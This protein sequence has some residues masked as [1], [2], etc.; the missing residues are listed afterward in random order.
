MIPL[1][2][3]TQPLELMQGRETKARTWL[4]ERCARLELGK[5]TIFEER[6]IYRE[7]NVLPL[8]GA[9]NPSGSTARG[10]RRALSGAACTGDH[11]DYYHP[12][13]PKHCSICITLV[14]TIMFWVKK[15]LKSLQALKNRKPNYRSSLA[16]HARG[17][18]IS[19]QSLPYIEFISIYV[20]HALTEDQNGADYSTSNK[21]KWDAF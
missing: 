2:C 13:C 20:L 14:A 1:S 12:A 15:E 7:L 16:R 17:A 19:P 5:Q 21:I 18:H 6:L 8:A 9:A 3:F 4:E 11:P 10:F